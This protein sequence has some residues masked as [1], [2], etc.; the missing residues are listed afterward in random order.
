MVKGQRE[1]ELR[2]GGKFQALEDEVKEKSHEAVRLTTVL[3]LKITS[4][5]E[6]VKK[7]KEIEKN[8]RE[9]EKSLQEK[10]R[11][12]DGLKEA[13]DAA[14]TEFDA[15]NNESEKKEELLQTLLTGVASKE[16]QENG[17]QNQL[18]GDRF[19]LLEEPS[20]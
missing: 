1:K 18:Q 9:L 19:L 3:D 15:L 13:Y 5:K 12:Y 4:I 10:S 8:V 17:Y 14:K 2:K 20:G 6:E 11:L 7:R 16:G